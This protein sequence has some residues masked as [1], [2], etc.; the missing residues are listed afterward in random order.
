[1]GGNLLGESAA[2]T[3]QG[4]QRREGL[5]ERWGGL[6]WRAGVGGEKVC[7][8]GSGGEGGAGTRGMGGGR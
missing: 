7:V 3:R 1:M 2:R 5:R 6:W 8:G 4:R